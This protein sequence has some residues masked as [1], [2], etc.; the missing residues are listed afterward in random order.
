MLGDGLLI[1]FTTGFFIQQTD[2]PNP[3]L[4]N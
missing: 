4:S 2:R 3:E 1:W